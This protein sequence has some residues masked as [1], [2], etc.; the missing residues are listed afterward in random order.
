MKPSV[1][2]FRSS[3]IARQRYVISKAAFA[4]LL[5]KLSNTNYQASII[6]PHG[7]GKSVL[8]EDIRRVLQSN[9][10]RTQ[11]FYLNTSSTRQEQLRTLWSILKSPHE[12]ICFLDGGETL[13]TNLWFLFLLAT[14]LR[15]SPLLATVHKPC[16]L[17]IVY[18]THAD[19]DRALILTA[20]LAGGAW[21]ED[22]RTLATNTFSKHEGN[23]REIFRSCYMY[24]SER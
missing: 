13:G 10:K 4:G 2:P 8:L 20:N 12:Q 3:A 23:C 9:G 17:P 15:R 11:W 14:R 18:E 21:N 6:G 22:M 19:L 7:T 5:N 16:A 24:C 1:N